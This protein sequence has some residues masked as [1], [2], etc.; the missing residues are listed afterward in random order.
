[1]VPV[2]F[3]VGCWMLD[4]RCSLFHF[5]GLCPF[6]PLRKACWLCSKN[7]GRKAS[8]NALSHSVS[9]S[10][11]CA[12]NAPSNATFRLFLFV[13][14]SRLTA[15]GVINTPSGLRKWRWG[16]TCVGSSTSRKIRFA[17]RHHRAEHRV[18][19]AHV[20]ADRTAALAHALDF[21]LLHVKAGA[22]RPRRRECP[23]P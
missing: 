16:S 23:R 21:A 17:R 6:R 7:S 4:V 9:G 5:P 15:S 8:R 20:A 2:L 18:P 14:F 13:S 10:G 11:R 1:M 22:H 19:K 12:L 3:D